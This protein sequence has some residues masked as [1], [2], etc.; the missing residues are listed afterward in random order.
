MIS[1]EEL[2][3]IKPYTENDLLAA[4]KRN[5]ELDIQ[6]FNLLPIEI[7]DFLNYSEVPIESHIAAHFYKINEYDVNKTINRLEGLVNDFKRRYFQRY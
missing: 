3:G 2:C 6:F 5:S 1:I 7:R 4:R